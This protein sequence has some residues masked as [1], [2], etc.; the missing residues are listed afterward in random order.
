[1]TL[2]IQILVWDRHRNVA[3]LNMLMGFQSPLLIIVSPTGM[4]I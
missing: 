3:R 1:M 2:E 4:Q